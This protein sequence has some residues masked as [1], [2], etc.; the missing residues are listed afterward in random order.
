M[1]V[2][3]GIG[4]SNHTASRFWEL[5]YQKGIKNLL[6]VRS[7]PK[8]RFPHFNSN[9][10]RDYL[11][12]R[13]M[14]YWH[15]PA[16]GGKNPRPVSEIMSSLESMRELLS[17]S[18]CA[19]MCSEGDYLTCHRHY[20]LAPVIIDL[21]YHYSQITPKGEIIEDHGPTEKTLKKFAAFLPVTHPFRQPALF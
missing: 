8:S 12:V 10:L 5:L 17:G 3:Y 2:I 4:H 1:A 18:D 6:D 11:T 14:S 21:G 15:T 7:W 19:L 20:L 9:P 13:N 16:L